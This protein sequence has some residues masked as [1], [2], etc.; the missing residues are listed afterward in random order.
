MRIWFLSFFILFAAMASAAVAQDTSKQET[1]K[2]APEISLRGDD[3]LGEFERDGLILEKLDVDI[4]IRAGLA[5]ISLGATLRNETDDEVEAS[6]AYP[7]PQGAVINGY[8]LDLDEELV[9]GVLLPKERAEKLYTDRVTQSIGADAVLSGSI[10]PRLS[11]R[12]GCGCLS[13]QTRLLNRL[14]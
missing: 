5:Q 8:A 7:L 13:P 6:F 1:F 9:N 14:A 11:R 2:N 4:D 12:A 10:L 3:D